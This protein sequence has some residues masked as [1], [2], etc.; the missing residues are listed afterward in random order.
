MRFLPA[1]FAALIGLS[2]V[3]S[4]VPATADVGSEKARP[5]RPKPPKPPKTRGAPAPVVG[6][7]LPILVLVGGA[8]WLVRRRNNRLVEQREQ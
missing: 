5:A 1:L 2:F 4:S 6:V 3:D 8:Y 7:G